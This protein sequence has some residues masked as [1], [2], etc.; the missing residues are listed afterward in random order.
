MV[1]AKVGRIQQRQDTS[2]GELLLCFA[3][4]PAKDLYWTCKQL[5]YAKTVLEADSVA[6]KMTN[7]VVAGRV[8][9]CLVQIYCMGRK[10]AALMGK[11]KS[12]RHRLFPDENRQNQ[13]PANESMAENQETP[14]LGSPHPDAQPHTDLQAGAGV[15]GSECIPSVL[16]SPH[17]SLETD[18]PIDSHGRRC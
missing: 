16:S 12:Y 7:G 3:C 4:G 17:R 8:L 5:N 14:D 13:T 18:S 15:T 10:W 9:L 6:L 1:F 11:L 2:R